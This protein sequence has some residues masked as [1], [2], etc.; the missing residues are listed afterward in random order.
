MVHRPDP[1]VDALVVELDGVVHRPDG[2]SFHLTPSLRAGH[3]AI[4]AEQLT[5]TAVRRGNFTG[6]GA[7][8][9]DLR[10]SA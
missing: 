4:E 10:P 3:E 2:P 6:L 1:G 8:E 5:T 9:L 7:I